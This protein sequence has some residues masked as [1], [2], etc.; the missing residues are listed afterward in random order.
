MAPGRNTNKN[1]EGRVHKVRA[2]ILPS[3]AGKVLQFAARSCRV[4]LLPALLV[5]T[6]SYAQVSVSDGGTPVYSYSIKAPPGVAGMSPNLGLLYS[7]SRISGPLGYA[8]TIQGISLITRCPTNV[9]DDGVIRGVV[10]ASGDKLCL[11]GQRLI[12]TDESGNPAAVQ[13]ANGVPVATQVND[14]AG[15]SA[16]YREYRT[17]K[18]SFARI[19]AYGS[20]G[21]V[22]ANGPAY[23]K[24]WTKAGQ[25]YEY[26][27]SLSADGNTNALVAAQGTSVAMVWAVSRISDTLGNYIDFKYIQRDTA[28]GTPLTGGVPQL[29][30]EWNL[31]EVQYTGNGAQVPSNKIV[32]D[33]ADRGAAPGTAQDRAEAYQLGS[34]NVSI[35]RLQAVRTYVNWSGPALGVTP[36]GTSFPYPLAPASPTSA[37]VPVAPPGG[38]VKVSAIKIA[39]SQGGNS[40]RSLVSSITQCASDESKCQPPVTF[41]YTA[42]GDQSFTP[43]PTFGISNALTTMKMIDA[44]TGNFGVVLGDF[45][46]DGLTDILRWGNNPTDNQLWLSAGTGAFTQPTQFN[47]GGQQLFSNDGCYV[48]IIADFNGDGRADVLR[49]AGANGNSCGGGNL[50]FLSNGD[51]SFQTPIALPAAID[52][53]TVK[54]KI[55]ATR[56][57]CG[58]LVFW[59]LRDGDLLAVADDDQIYAQGTGNCWWYTK[60]TGKAFHLIDVDGDGILDI[61]TTI[62]PN[63]AYGYSNIDGNTPA[64]TP[65][66][67]CASPTICTH[68]YRGSPQGVFTE[69]TGTSLAHHS[70]YYDPV[71]TGSY[72]AFFRP[73]VA[74]LD[75]DGLADLSVK[76]GIWRSTGD[77]NFTGPLAGVSGS[78]GNPI[79][80]NGDGRLDCLAASTFGQSLS[81]MTGNLLS[82]VS[83]FNLTS[84]ANPDQTL[85]A[86]NTTTQQQS[87]G[88]LIGDFDGDG[89]SDILRWEDAPGSNALFL[90]NGDGTFRPSTTFNL[91]G[92][93][94]TL[95]NSD[96]KTSYLAGD[97]TGHGTLEILR[98]KDSPSGSGEG[99]TNQLYVRNDPTPPDLLS[100]VVSPTGL[101][102]TLTYVPLT[103]SASG[104]IGTRYTA[105]SP[106][107]YPKVNVAVP[108]YV[109]ATV[110]TD[111]GIGGQGPVVSEYSY[112][113][114]R[115]H[116]Q[117]R[118]LLGFASRSQQTPGPSGD[119]LTVISLYLQDYPYI[120]I[121]STSLTTNGSIYSGGSLLSRTTNAYCDMTSASAPGTIAVGPPP[122]APPPCATTSMVQRPYLAQSFEE[123]WDL[124]GQVLPTVTTTN[125]FTNPAD[126]HTNTG[127]PLSIT[128]QTQGTALGISQTSTKTTT[129]TYSPDVTSGNSW[130]LGRLQQATQRNI[131][132]NSLSS[133]A[134]VAGSAP[135]A[136]SIQGTGQTQ[137]ATLSSSIAFGNVTASTSSTLSATLANTGASSLAITVPTAASVSGAGFAFA[138]TTCSASLPAYASC[139]VSVTFTP[140]A[141]SAYAGT[142]SVTTGAAALTS[143][144]SGTGVAPAVVF[145]PVL[146]NWGVIGASSDSGD[147][148]TIKNNSAVSVL[149]TAHATL[150]GPA[151]M[152]SWQGTS[153]YCVPGTTVLAPGASCQ[154]FFGTAA[155]SAL[156]SYSAT[157]QISY[158]AV[159]VTSTTYTTQQTY[160]FSIATTT[161]NPSS[162]AFGNV[163]PNTTSTA[164]SIVLTNNAVNGGALR[165]LSITMIGA[166][167]ANFPMTHNCGVALAQGASCTVSVSF[168]PT[169][170]GNGFGASVQVQGGY[171]RMQAG[172]E[173]GYICCT[174]VNLALPVSGNGTGSSVTTTADNAS[175]LTATYGAAPATG[176]VTF[177]NAGNQAATLTMS[178]L[179]GVYSVAPSTCTAGANGGTCVVTVTMTTNG[180][181]G[182]QG[183]QTLTATGGTTGAATA[184]VNGVLNG[185]LVTVSVDNASALSAAK[186]GA[187][188]SGTV[189]FANSGNQAASLTLSGLSGAYSVAPTTCTAAA[190]G[191]TCVV[192]VTMTTAGSI[193][194]QGAQTLSATGG[195]TGAANAAVAGTLTGSIATLT[196]AAPNLGNVYV[197]AASPSANVTF[198]NDGNVALTISG[199]A[200]NSYAFFPVNANSCSAVAPGASCTITIGMATGAAGS[201]PI[202][203][204]T[205][206]ATVVASFSINGSVSSSV[207]S[208][209]VTSL[210]FG[211]VGLGAQ[212]TQNITLSNVGYGPL[213][214]I[215]NGALVNLPAGF[216]ANTSAC[217]SVPVGGNCNVAITFSPTAAQAYGGGSISPSNITSSGNLLSVSGTG[218]AS[219]GTLSVTPTSVTLTGVGGLDYLSSMI[220]VSN[221]GPGT[222]S[223]LTVN[224]VRISGTIGS[225]SLDTNT[226]SGQTLTSGGTCT[227]RIDFTA[228]CPNNATSRWNLNT[229]GT[230]AANTAVVTVIGTT[231]FGVCR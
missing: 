100:A 119:P 50:L 20:A 61:I 28:W 189:T 202:P 157:D 208:W 90:S 135:G 228:G 140:T 6:V 53:S 223:N 72:A 105:G 161:A 117:G 172:V 75:G 212:S 190:N 131:V 198:R 56:V 51:G 153:G 215:W 146:V 86:F 29:G 194:A 197:G 187:N 110:R 155:A 115:A 32:F 136:S 162:L 175:G 156:G 60:T 214:G 36:Q 118:G 40:G 171:E 19:R 65:D 9:A 126:P 48:S 84:L 35:W 166:Q 130:V 108:I 132:P 15:L 22:P 150:S 184:A 141:A 149:I 12:Q 3:T 182:A 47:L 71:P 221:A 144:L 114:L 174:S 13:N 67:L 106:V 145:Q 38:A 46:G 23:F 173:S 2:S 229:T 104:S 21:G 103:S 26:G 151:G 230:Q 224:F 219:T 101:R 204:T 129:N 154:T 27:A 201:G 163:A 91:T 107:S 54:E 16:G 111:T 186:G 4:L 34:K 88:T 82:P 179:S 191:G 168:N 137:F 195:T 99:T 211:N 127:D 218:V 142:L 1:Q 210:A 77:G 164:Q 96:G 122:V 11:D 139:T 42:G 159:G 133:I 180:A 183:A 209:S 87:A 95:R 193:G 93:N 148:P 170:I 79:D 109:V 213:N 10:F 169:W 55:T 78:C 152:W 128:V 24:V 199:L 57:N 206:G 134:T 44:T 158:Q 58:P 69:F 85:Y 113:G 225:V 33:Y 188:A 41:Q 14:S 81:V 227:L 52:L 73:S 94:Q 226:C 181:I 64:P 112:Q 89:R 167:P 74:D 31:V 45:N 160:T 8:W 207:S 205:T 49:I 80:F 25:I 165:N 18:D 203:V 185:S 30:R 231:Q 17:E 102:T 37:G 5:A 68:V 177:T 176:T 147:W 200:G 192:T 59:P 92:A 143:T 121:A 7:G 138:S 116:L 125:V 70:V 217:A 66:S 178:G 220:T 196:S 63:S 124:N 97:F 83:N 120:G 216:A 43:N 123:G 39:Y 222:V 62:N 98:M 76:T